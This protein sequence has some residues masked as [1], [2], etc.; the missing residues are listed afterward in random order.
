MQATLNWENVV[1]GCGWKIVFS[2]NDNDD[3]P[4]GKSRMADR[5]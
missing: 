1:V 5:L 2:I 3:I 4:K